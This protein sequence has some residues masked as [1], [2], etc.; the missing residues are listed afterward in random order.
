MI[1][2]NNSDQLNV[3]DDDQQAEPVSRSQCGRRVSL[4]QRLSPGRRVSPGDDMSLLDSKGDDVCQETHV[5]SRRHTLSPLE[6]NEVPLAM[7]GRGLSESS[8]LSVVHKNIPNQTLIVHAL[9]GAQDLEE[10]MSFTEALSE[11]D[12]HKWK[13]AIDFEYNSIIQNQTWKLVPLPIGRKTKC[14][15]V[16]QMD[17]QISAWHS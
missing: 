8:G 15:I 11:P 9:M 1:I 12:S 2:H 6:W 14:M 3:T 13:E 10:P 16:H 7:Q 5:V 4:G 17:V